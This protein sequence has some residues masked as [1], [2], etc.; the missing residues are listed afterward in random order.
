MPFRSHFPRSQVT[1]IDRSS[2]AIRSARRKFGEQSFFTQDV[3]TTPLPVTFDVL[4]ATNVLQYFEAPWR[5]LGKLG[6]HVARHLLVS[7]PFRIEGHRY[8]FDDSTI[9]THIDPDF[10]LSSSKIYRLRDGI[11]DS[12]GLQPVAILS[13]GRVRRSMRR[14]Q[15]RR[16]RGL[17]DQMRRVVR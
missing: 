10:V 9:G 14:R 11:A 5:V 16:R 17:R 4:A 3:L 1:G 6:V 15:R 7:V 13:A 8:T 2:N 12:F